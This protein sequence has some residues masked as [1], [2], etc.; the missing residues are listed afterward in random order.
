LWYLLIF[1][2]YR[3]NL[4]K[5]WCTY[6]QKLKERW[7]RESRVLRLSCKWFTP[8]SVICWQLS[9]KFLRIFIDLLIKAQRKAPNE[10]HG[11]RLFS[12]GSLQYL[13]FQRIYSINSWGSSIAYSPKLRERCFKELR[14]LTP[15]CKW[16]TPSSV[17]WRQLLD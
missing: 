12:N 14:V 6:L 11:G 13:L 3:F 15:A 8:T 10:I 4:P 5:Y 9:N 17:I 2:S 1:D 16:L 7:S